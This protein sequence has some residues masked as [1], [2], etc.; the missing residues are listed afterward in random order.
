LRTARGLAAV[1]R[2]G[3]ALG[4]LVTLCVWP[5]TGH[6]EPDIDTRVKFAQVERNAVLGV[7][8]VSDVEIDT[9]DRVLR[10]D[11]LRYNPRTGRAYTVA[12]G[13]LLH[14]D[15][16]VE[17]REVILLDQRMRRALLKA[18]PDAAPER[19]PRPGSDL[20]AGL[21]RPPELPPRRAAATQLA[22]LQPALPPQPPA[23]RDAGDAGAATLRLASARGAEAR[24]AAAAPEPR[25]DARVRA[26]VQLAA[27][28]PAPAAASAPDRLSLGISRAIE[29]S[30]ADARHRARSRAV[31]H[32]TE[33]AERARWNP[34]VRVLAGSTLVDGGTN[35]TGLERAG[36]FEAT[37]YGG[38]GAALRLYDHGRN[39]VER[40]LAAVEADRVDADRR[41]A[42]ADTAAE[43]RAAY[44]EARIARAYTADLSALKTRIAAWLDQAE[45][46]Y[47]ER[48]IPS[49]ALSQ[50]ETAAADVDTRIA[51]A[52]QRLDGAER[53]WRA[54]TG[55]D[56]DAGDGAWPGL[57]RVPSDPALIAAVEDSPEVRR[58]ATDQ[59]RAE[60]ELRQVRVADGPTVDLRA[61][62]LQS[63][64]G[65]PGLFVGLAGEMPVFDNGVNDS[66]E[67][68]ALAEVNAARSAHNAAVRDI[69]HRAL[70]VRDQLQRLDR[71]AASD[72]GRVAR[73]Q[74]RLQQVERR[75]RVDRAAV[76]ELAGEVRRLA[77]ALER[78]HA[79]LR[80]TVRTRNRLLTTLGLARN[81]DLR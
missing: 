9:G 53:Q 71:E 17:F 2:G 57:P 66:R 8:A 72:Q 29:R 19:A 26:G 54:L 74:E 27:A 32:E 55:L 76:P 81:L 11:R 67:A 4:A 38:V 73:A 42:N 50:L 59:R 44:L 69:R 56:L 63:L 22:A 79:T 1:L 28:A 64:D 35:R 51:T 36:D 25:G 30:D 10:A 24:P 78:R 34:H 40:Q 37:A 77:A 13:V 18:M 41:A 70:E 61:D 68:A 6:G 49:D 14:P 16:Q 60:L 33:A 52:R 20:Q 31:E 65:E 45:L 23:W 48:L 12:G 5:L 47:R 46:R 15:G 80:E 39:A 75:F 21:P 7:R 3:V 43:V 62:A 58:T